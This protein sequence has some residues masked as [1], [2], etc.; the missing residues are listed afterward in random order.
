MME[1]THMA[2]SPYSLRELVDRIEALRAEAAEADDRD[3][4][5]I[6]DLALNADMKAIKECQRVLAEALA[7]RG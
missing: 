2:M 4:V 6:C 1:D 3:M 7:Q 5:H